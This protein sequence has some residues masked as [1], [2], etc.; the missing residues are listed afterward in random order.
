MKQFFYRQGLSAG[1]FAALAVAVLAS[2]VCIP[3]AGAAEFTPGSRPGGISPDIHDDRPDDGRGSNAPEGPFTVS[4]LYQAFSC[5]ATR[6]GEIYWKAGIDTPDGVMREFS[7]KDDGATVKITI[8]PDNGEAYPYLYPDGPWKLAI[9]AGGT[10]PSWFTAEMRAAA[11]GALEEWKA[12][13]YNFDLAAFMHPSNPATIAPHQPAEEDIML[14]REWVCSGG[15]PRNMIMRSVS[16]AIGGTVANALW[17]YLNTEFWSPFMDQANVGSVVS[18]TTGLKNVGAIQEGQ[19]AAYFGSYFADLMTGQGTNPNTD[20]P[21]RA[22][23][24]LINRGFIVSSDAVTWRLHNA[25]DGSVA[26]SLSAEAFKANEEQGFVVIVSETGATYWQA[27]I[28]SSDTIMSLFGLDSGNYLKA[29]VVPDNDKTYPYLYPDLPWKLVLNGEAPVW[30]S[31]T[32][33]KAVM[34]AFEEWKAYVYDFD[35]D[36]LLGF[37]ANLPAEPVLPK[38]EDILLLREWAA[39]NSGSERSGTKGADT[40]YPWVGSSIWS[41]AA[42]YL[43]DAF[44]DAYG[45]CPGPTVCHGIEAYYGITLDTAVEDLIGSSVGEAALVGSFFT[46]TERWQDSGSEVY[47]YQVCADLWRHGFI[48]SFDGVT[49]RLSS[50]PEGTVVYEITEIASSK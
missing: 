6:S 7:L 41:N 12:V 45:Q 22:A 17:N 11:M 18:R 28:E 32:H 25:A 24:E 8:T 23:V 40:R 29:S 4:A 15:N 44:S 50:G 39:F 27:G 26:Y 33:E 37:F 34:A 19:Y 13:V 36:G 10:T 1:M 46:N 31:P 2:T 16:S 20:Y 42:N 43:N 3:S 30:Y 35:I 48:A 9:A 47:P 49:W 21:Y 5:V 14:F 38:E